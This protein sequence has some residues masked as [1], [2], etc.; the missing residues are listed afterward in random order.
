[1]LSIFVILSAALI[2]N[3]WKLTFYFSQKFEI[4]SSDKN[5]SQCKKNQWKSNLHQKNRKMNRKENK[6][7]QSDII[8]VT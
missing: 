2:P 6:N 3:S 7:A 4:Y 8:F 5:C 1:M